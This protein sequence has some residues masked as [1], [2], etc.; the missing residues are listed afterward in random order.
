MPRDPTSRIVTFDHQPTATDL[1][2]D[3]GSDLIGS[4]GFEVTD[5][6]KVFSI[7]PQ[8]IPPA[9]VVVVLMIVI[10]SA[11]VFAWLDDNNLSLWG[12][13]LGGLILILPTFYFGVNWLN[14]SLGDDPYLVYEKPINQIKLPRHSVK[15]STTQIREVVVLDRFVF[16]SKFDTGTQFWQIGLVIEEGNGTWTYAH[17]YNSSGINGEIK[18]LGIK[19]EYTRLA[20]ALGI[21]KRFIT[22][23][24]EE[25]K[26]LFLQA[27]L[28]NQ[29]P[30]T[31][32]TASA[33]SV[34]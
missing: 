16:G 21:E 8:K 9:F 20:E 4:S 10:V 18:W 34:S 14:E 27:S 13:A 12:I 3:L 24:Q 19:N 32:F 1:A 28:P 25:S 17:L 31:S 5:D 29:K 22:L 6:D 7:G 2:T 26:A 15:F 11:G 30:S 33:S 23:T